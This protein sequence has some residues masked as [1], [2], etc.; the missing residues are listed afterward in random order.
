MLVSRSRTLESGERDWAL[1]LVLVLKAGCAELLTPAL[2]S[3]PLSHSFVDFMGFEPMGFEAYLSLGSCGRAAFCLLVSE[4]N[5]P[6]SDFS[7]ALRFGESRP[8]V[9]S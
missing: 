1:V 7:N 3:F 8:V 2:P 4:K 9:L 6:A 5:P